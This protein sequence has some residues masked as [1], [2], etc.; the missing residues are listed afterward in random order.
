MTRPSAPKPKGSPSLSQ[1]ERPGMREGKGPMVGGKGGETARWG[2]L[3]L[4]RPVSLPPLQAVP[5]EAQYRL[6]SQNQSGA[7]PSAQCPYL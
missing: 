2:R 4:P 5:P 6:Q 3:P 7:L 1:M